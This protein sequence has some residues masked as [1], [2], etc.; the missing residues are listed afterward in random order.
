MVGGCGEAY[1]LI[2]STRGDAM[3]PEEALGFIERLYEQRCGTGR[4]SFEQTTGVILDLGNFDRKDAERVRRR[5]A[6]LAQTLP[7]VLPT[8]SDVIKAGELCRHAADRLR[9]AAWWVELVEDW[10][11]PIAHEV[12]QLATLLEGDGRAEPAP[13]AALLQLRDTVETL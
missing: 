3:S 9:G 5:I 7:I 10:P 12:R 1:V 4:D 6:E 13:E 8:T 2:G 11:S